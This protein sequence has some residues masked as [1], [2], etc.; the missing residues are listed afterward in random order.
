[1][2]RHVGYAADDDPRFWFVLDVAVGREHA[3]TLAGP[4]ATEVF[5]VLPRRLIL[6]S[7]R[8]ALVC[9]H[10]HDPTG[11]QVVFAACRA[12]VLPRIWA[13][14]TDSVCLM[15]SCPAVRGAARPESR[16]L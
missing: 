12:V 13:T 4:S 7:L 15:P 3:S 14:R 5:P 2:T 10:R 1:M 6:E 9:Q 16:R 8:E 11:V